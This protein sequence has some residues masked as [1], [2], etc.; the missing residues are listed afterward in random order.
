MPNG[1]FYL[2]SLDRSISVRRDELLGFL[3]PCFIENPVF[4]ANC[5][6]PAQMPHPAASGLGLHCLQMSLLWEARHKWVNQEY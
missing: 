6:D 2:H 5:V 1:F 3:L 4:N